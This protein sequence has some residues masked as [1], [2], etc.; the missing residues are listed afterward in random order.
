MAQQTYR[1]HTHARTRKW[2]LSMRV[3]LFDDTLLIGSV[4]TL[5]SLQM[6]AQSL[7]STSVPEAAAALSS[8][9]AKGLLAGTSEPDL[10]GAARLPV[11]AVSRNFAFLHLVMLS[12]GPFFFKKASSFRD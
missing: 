6:C 2:L 5:M 11:L 8:M 7:L 12:V 10:N 1:T 3:Y 4:V 9:Y